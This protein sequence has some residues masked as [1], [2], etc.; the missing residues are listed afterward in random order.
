MAQPS[1]MTYQ[2]VSMLAGEQKITLFS[3]MGEVVDIPHNGDYDTGKIMAYLKGKITGM[4]EVPLDLSGYLVKKAT[5][6][7][8]VLADGGI[9]ITQVINGVTV[10]GIFYP[11]KPE[12]QIKIAG[13][14]VVVPGVENLLRHAK[15]AN[16]HNPQAI[17]NFLERMVPVLKDRK[18][19]A[20]DLMNFIGSSEMPLTND[21]RI[22]CYKRVKK[23]NIAGVY[24]DNA[25]HMIKQRVGSRVFMDVEK[26]DPSRYNS[27]SNGLHVANQIYMRE[28]NGD[29][30]ML[31]L[32]SPEDFIAVP[33]NEHGKARVCAYDVIGI[34]DERAHGELSSGYVK[35][36]EGL[37]GIIAQAIEG[38]HVQ[39][40]EMVHAGQKTLIKIT[41]IKGRREVTKSKAKVDPKTLANTSSLDTDAP[42]PQAPD[43][44]KV[45]AATVMNTMSKE[46][47]KIPDDVLKAFQLMHDGQSKGAAGRAVGT[48]DRSVGR[49]MDKYGY[50]L[51]LKAS[52]V[53]PQAG[54]LHDEP[55]QEELE[56]TSAFVDKLIANGG[57]N[58]GMGKMMPVPEV[59]P[60]DH[61]KAFI[62]YNLW[63]NLGTQA[64]WDELIDFKKKA[65]KGWNQLGLTAAQIE[66]IMT[67]MVNKD[68]L[69]KALE[70][71]KFDLYVDW[72]G[73]TKLITLIKEVRAFLGLGLKE[74]KDLVESKASI[75]S[76]AAA[77]DVARF[78]K[79]LMDQ[80][81]VTE[82][83]HHGEARKVMPKVE[84]KSSVQTPTAPLS[85][86]QQAHLLFEA[87]DW[88]A[89]I[90]FKKTAKKGW[91]ALGFTD[92]EI[93]Q[94]T[95]AMP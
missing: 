68:K 32:V 92:N 20:E 57:T 26:V 21:G 7:N 18:H 33:Q 44:A 3:A 11:K 74:A 25:S 47:I 87:K 12:T 8:K 52:V 53:A 93:G 58:E 54:N 81:F 64:A 63:K 80:G 79:I 78:T 34:M 40:F 91:D 71:G 43:E 59:Q 28:F 56:D 72:E 76:D 35:S 16:E 45:D 29:V 22:I 27:C 23:T 24:V 67:H 82:T 94:I 2:V 84:V 65:N 95:K 14:N 38:K 86:A 5:E 46:A 75:L 17:K 6:I 41:P 61:S 77:A 31:V 51:W 49:W 13:E 30:T 90:Q 83:V 73:S 1:K 9:E 39:P 69:V 4:N 66:D 50:D 70:A 88:S 55:T 62:L 10:Q 42:S 15:R 19:S 48:S 36:N 60:A 89:L 37:K 85:K